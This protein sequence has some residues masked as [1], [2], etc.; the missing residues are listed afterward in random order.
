MDMLVTLAKALIQIPRTVALLS[1]KG[2]G[3][4]L[5]LFARSAEADID[6]GKL[7]RESLRAYGGKGGGRPDFAQGSAPDGHLVL[8]AALEM[9]NSK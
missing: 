5:L 9:L 1:G 4:D 7:L 2:D 3:K 6:I 8:N